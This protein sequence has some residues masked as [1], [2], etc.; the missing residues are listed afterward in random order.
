MFNQS[1]IL[2][3]IINI[4]SGE[5]YTS[6]KQTVTLL[7]VISS[8]RWDTTFLLNIFLLLYFKD[9]IKMFYSL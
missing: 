8:N 7:F 2:D 3:Y 6:A 1:K 4:T 9:L 5:N